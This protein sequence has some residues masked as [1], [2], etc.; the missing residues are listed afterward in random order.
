M[1]FHLQNQISVFPLL[2]EYT[3][4][5]TASCGVAMLSKGLF[6]GILLCWRLLTSEIP[7]SLLPRDAETELANCTPGKENFAV[8]FAGN[9]MMQITYFHEKLLKGIT[10]LLSCSS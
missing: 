9:W 3:S 4:E 2:Y 7:R 1:G 10:G 8:T 6:W 5:L